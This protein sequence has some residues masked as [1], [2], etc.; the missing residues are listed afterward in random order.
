MNSTLINLNNKEFDLNNVCKVSFDLNLLKNFLFNL[1]EENFNKY[2]NF[3]FF[4]YKFKKQ[5]I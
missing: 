4:F 5:Y 2:Q 1:L 3:F